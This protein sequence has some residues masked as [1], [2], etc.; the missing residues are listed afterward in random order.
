M[1]QKITPIEIAE[2]LKSG[3]CARCGKVQQTVWVWFVWMID[4]EEWC[5][6]CAAGLPMEQL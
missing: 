2:R 5:E 4:Y 1:D 3:T 6:E